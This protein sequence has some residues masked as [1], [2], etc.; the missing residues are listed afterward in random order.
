MPSIYT[1]QTH[2][3]VLAHAVRYLTISPYILTVNDNILETFPRQYREKCPYS[4]FCLFT[5]LHYFIVL[6]YHSLF[7][8]PLMIDSSGCIVKLSALCQSD[9]G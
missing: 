7:K 1:N 9:R 6:M 2:S 3:N 8:Q 5:A 4:L